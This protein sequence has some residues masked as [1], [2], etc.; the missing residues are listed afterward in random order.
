MLDLI[1]LVLIFS[2]LIAFFIYYKKEEKSQFEQKIEDDKQIDYE[3]GIELIKVDKNG[4]DYLAATYKDYQQRKEYEIKKLFSPGMIINWM[5]ARWE[6]ISTP[7]YEYKINYSATKY[8]KRTNYYYVKVRYISK[9]TEQGGDFYNY[10]VISKI[11]DSKFYDSDVHIENQVEIKNE[12]VKKIDGF[13]RI[14]STNDVEILE[15]KKELKLIRY[16]VL[17]NEVDTKDIPKLVEKMKKFSQTS[18]PFASLLS[19]IIGL[20]QKLI[21]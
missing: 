21:Y 16:E 4:I 18:A 15:L 7:E 6:V 11:S 2:I 3:S 13:L 12:L 8:E 20:V 10:G 5:N 14:D 17:N 1:K 19:A 9:M